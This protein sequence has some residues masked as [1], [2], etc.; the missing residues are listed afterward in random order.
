MFYGPNSLPEELMLLWSV[1]SIV[2]FLEKRCSDLHA[3]FDWR[4]TSSESENNIE[5]VM[6]FQQDHPTVSITKL[7]RS[8]VGGS[9]NGYPWQICVCDK[10]K[11]RRLQDLSAK[12]YSVHSKRCFIFTTVNNQLQA[13]L[14]LNPRLLKL[15]I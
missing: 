11:R 12:P 14:M 10:R 7:Q 3:R 2:S 15:H 5:K 13:I 4:L 1:S 6:A 8:G 9:L